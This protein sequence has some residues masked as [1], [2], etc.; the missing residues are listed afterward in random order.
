MTDLIDVSIS[1]VAVIAIFWFSILIVNLI[2]GSKI[3]QKQSALKDYQRNC[4]EKNKHIY[5]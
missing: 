1:M 4:H 2:K 5:Y 3:F